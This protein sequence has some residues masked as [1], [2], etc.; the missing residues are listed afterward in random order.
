MPDRPD[1]NWRALRQ[2][3]L[4][5]LYEMI[6]EN[7]DSDEEAMRTAEVGWELGARANVVHPEC[8]QSPPSLN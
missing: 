1:D 5:S 7:F 4:E 8:R 2:L 3:E 6:R